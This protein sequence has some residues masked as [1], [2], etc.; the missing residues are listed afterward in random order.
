MTEKVIPQKIMLQKRLD[1]PRPIHEHG[2]LEELRKIAK[3]NLVFRSYIGMGYYG[4]ISPSVIVRQLL[5]NAGWLVFVC[6]KDIIFSE[7]DNQCN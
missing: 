5:E 7:N 6:N 1:L 3:T 2:M 4:C